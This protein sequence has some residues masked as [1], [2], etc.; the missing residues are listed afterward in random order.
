MQAPR[1]IHRVQQGKVR[2][3]PDGEKVPEFTERRLRR[4]HL[5]VKERRKVFCA[6]WR[7]IHDR[8]SIA[9]QK[10]VREREEVVACLAVASANLRRSEGAIGVI[11]MRMD[12]TL[13][14]AAGC[15]ECGIDEHGGDDPFRETVK[16]PYVG[17]DADGCTT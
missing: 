15:G 9:F 17:K 11:G 7:R 13:E 2:R 3:Q 14:E 1:R 10:M 8:K 5:G 6:E 16:H 12:V 4:M